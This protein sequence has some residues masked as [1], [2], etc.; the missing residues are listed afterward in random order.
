MSAMGQL[1]SSSEAVANGEEATDSFQ[2]NLHD[3][4]DRAGLWVGGGCRHV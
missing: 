3:A 2:S 1:R 4:L